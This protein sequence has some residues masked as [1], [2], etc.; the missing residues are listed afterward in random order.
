MHPSQAKTSHVPSLFDE[1]KD[2]L[3]LDETEKATLLN[4]LFCKPVKCGRLR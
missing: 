1:G 4:D 3:I 2:I